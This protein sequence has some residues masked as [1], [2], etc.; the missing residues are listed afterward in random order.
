MGRSF[1]NDG[2]S[3]RS[4]RD[5]EVS[6]TVLGSR[7]FFFFYFVLPS[8]V[9]FSL[10]SSSSFFLVESLFFLPRSEGR[11]VVCLLCSLCARV[12]TCLCL[13]AS[14]SLLKRRWKRLAER[15]SLQ[16]LYLQVKLA[17]TW[18]LGGLGTTTTKQKVGKEAKEIASGV[19]LYW[20]LG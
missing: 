7:T 10:F 4:L 15:C 11:G 17:L 5:S 1:E 13:C 19:Y 8:Y 20:L 9:F 16:L 3:G 18:V 2:R 14:L 12:R 6:C